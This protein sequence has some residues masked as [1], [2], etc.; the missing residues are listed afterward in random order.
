MPTNYIQ[1][2]LENAL[3][4]SVEQLYLNSFP[5]DERRDFLFVK[6]LLEVPNSPFNIIVAINDNNEFIGFISYW[7]WNDF[8]YIEHFA[9]EPSLRGGGMG[10]KMISDFGMLATSPI[11]LEVEPPIDEMA[12]RRIGFYKRCGYHLW[13]DVKYTQPAY[14]SSKNSLDLKIM[15]YGDITITENSEYISRIKREVYGAK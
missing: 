9:V 13:N 4:N 12:T 15:T 14:D 6:N 5:I 2:S 3:I 11:I 10:Q 8:R 1:I 7:E